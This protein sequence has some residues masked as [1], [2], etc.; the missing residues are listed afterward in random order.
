MKKLI[1]VIIVLL[2]LITLPLN[3]YANNEKN[4]V[5]N[6]NKYI[7]Y[8]DDGSYIVTEIN[9]NNI[10]TLA[11]VTNKTKSSIFYNSKNEKQW[12]VIVNGSFSYTGNSATCLNSSV[13]YKIYNTGM[14]KV[15]SANASKSGA[16]AIGDFVIKEYFIGIPIKTINK[17]LTLTC[18]NTGVCS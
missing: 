16:K 4:E 11:T 12:E 8:F 9:T 13:S 1:S 15:T 10:S 14:W 5:I 7:E 6:E 3:A 17:A 18:S 2:V